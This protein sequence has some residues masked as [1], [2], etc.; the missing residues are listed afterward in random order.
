[1]TWEATVPVSELKVRPRAF[2]RV[3]AFAW[4]YVH[5]VTS[6][7]SA[8]M[9]PHEHNRV[10]AGLCIEERAPGAIRPSAE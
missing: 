4:K 3:G 8:S 6:R 10:E 2:K 5:P 9:P 1:M 7:A